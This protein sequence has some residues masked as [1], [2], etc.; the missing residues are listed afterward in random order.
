MLIVREAK[1]EEES[2]KAFSIALKS[3]GLLEISEKKISI[4]K[5][6]W[7]DDPTYSYT[8]IIVASLKDEIIGLIRIIPRVINRL[9][10]KYNLAGLTSVCIDERHRGKGYSIPL[11]KETLN[12][13][14]KRGYDLAGLIARKAL[15]NYYTKFGFYG[16]SSYEQI[17]IA[18]K[19]VDQGFSFSQMNDFYIKKYAEFYDDNYSNCFGKIDRTYLIWKYILGLLNNRPKMKALSIFKNLDLFGYCFINDKSVV[20]LTM[21]S[22]F[23]ICDLLSSLEEKGYIE[24]AESWMDLPSNHK[25]IQNL[26]NTDI[27]IQSR[28]CSYGGHMACILNFESLVSMFN[29]RNQNL[30]ELENSNLNSYDLLTSLLGTY[31]ISKVKS[32][33]SNPLPFSFCFMDEF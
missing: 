17:K 11:M 21:S 32:M 2:Q 4:K 23:Y 18:G 25:L 1:N 33:D 22:N 7:N 27:R 31:R 29:Q 12:I 16:I 15:D 20:E 14:K 5:S 8:N 26:R 9:S 24:S 10:Q 30:F 3:F 28:E 6:I 19:G 13:A